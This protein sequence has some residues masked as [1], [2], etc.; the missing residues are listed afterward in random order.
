MSRLAVLAALLLVGPTAAFVQ[1]GSVPVPVSAA[2]SLEAVQR[3]YDAAL[4]AWQARYDATEDRKAKRALK[5]EHPAEAFAGRFLARLDGGELAAAL[6]LQD[7]L[8]D[9][10]LKRSERKA[11]QERLHVELLA[12]EDHGLRRE[13]IARLCKDLPYLRELGNAE[14]EARVR[15]SLELEPDTDQRGSAL[16]RVAKRLLSSRDAAEKER[17]LALLKD[18]VAP[19][20]AEGEEPWATLSAADLA[21]VEPL[22]FAAEFL[23]VG[24]VAQDF[25][26]ATV[27]G[28][29]LVMSELADGKVTVL[30]FFG[31][32]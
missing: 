2:D 25:T 1:A 19:D 20:L 27:D 12:S 5:K 31:F 22:L 16:V 28:D 17:G 6:W 4:A 3:E 10:G 24:A 32:W 29:E 15:R 18:L 8:R 11:L 26:G 9:L 7:H 13:G 23:S 21:D 30:Q 14:L